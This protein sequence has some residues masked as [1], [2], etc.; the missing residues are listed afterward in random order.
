MQPP[1]HSSEQVG[2]WQ[3]FLDSAVHDLRA[4]L[5]AIGTST[6]LLKEVCGERLNEEAKPLIVTIL[7]GVAKIESFSQAVASYSRAL[8]SNAPT[9]GFI[10][11]DSALRA[12]LA[13]LKQQIA[14]S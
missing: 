9:W 12:A 7:E 5:R 1:D 11:A 10:R 14:D 2:E 6:E 4:S 13:E 8:Q 3:R